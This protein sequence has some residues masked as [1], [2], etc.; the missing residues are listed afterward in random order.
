MIRRTVQNSLYIFIQKLHMFLPVKSAFKPNFN[1]ILILPGGNLY[2]ALSSLCVH[3]MRART[4][5]IHA[6]A[7]INA[8]QMCTQR[9]IL[10]E[11]LQLHF[12]ACTHNYASYVCTKYAFNPRTQS[13]FNFLNVHFNSSRIHADSRTEQAELPMTGSKEEA[14]MPN[15]LQLSE[16]KILHVQISWCS[17]LVFVSSLIIASSFFVLFDVSWIPF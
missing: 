15:A 10:C 8:F 16:V 7:Q 9:L 2:T 11:Q 12:Q 6:H 13:R 5:A 14:S 4:N 3:F 1:C 17:K